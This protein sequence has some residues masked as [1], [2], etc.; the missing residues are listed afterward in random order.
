VFNGTPDGATTTTDVDVNSAKDLA[1]RVV[2]QP[3]RS[4]AAGSRLSGLGFHL[5]GSH[6]TESGPLPSFR[7][8]IGQTYFAFVPGAAADGT[9]DRVSPAVFY[10]YRTVGLFGEYARSAQPVARGGTV[11]EVADDAWEVTG[12]IVLTGEA[13]SDRGVKPAASFDPSRGQWGALQVVA[14]VAELTV[15]RDVFTAGLQAP[16]S[17]R[18]ATSFAIGANWYPNAFVKYYLMY[19]RTTFDREFSNRAPE[20]SLVFRMQLAF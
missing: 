11:T 15:D 17:S 9:H 7:T 19:E 8:S 14:R 16:G 20:N 5:G 1:A 4:A 3:F 12:S 10:Y 18:R 6:G 2:W 13:S